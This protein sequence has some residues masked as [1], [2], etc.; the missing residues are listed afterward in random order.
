MKLLFFLS[1]LS[2]LTVKAQIDHAFF[3]ESYDAGM[4]VE[5]VERFEYHTVDTLSLVEVTK[6]ILKTKSIFNTDGFLKE[7]IWFNDGMPFQK[8]NYDY[9]DGR[10]N[11]SIY[12]EIKTNKRIKKIG[13][14]YDDKLLKVTQI[15]DD[16]IPIAEYFFNENGEIAKTIDLKRSKIK[17]YTFDKGLKSVK[18]YNQILEQISYT[19]QE[20]DADERLVFQKAHYEFLHYSN[21]NITK[22]KYFDL[23]ENEFIA[24]MFENEDL[25]TIYRKSIKRN[26][27]GLI[28]KEYTDPLRSIPISVVE[29]A[30]T[31][32]E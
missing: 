14:V 26:D 22:Y 29:Y 20:Y 27:K 3:I 1:C 21:T 12:C 18:S 10:M 11:V 30:Y 17:E 16:T 23:D 7:R 5:S 4:G 19:L 15:K 32:F 28:E 9:V 13:F 2:C 6:K 8:T 25:K 31:Y 24:Q